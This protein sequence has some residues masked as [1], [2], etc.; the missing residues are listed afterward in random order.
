MTPMRSIFVFF[1]FLLLN[2]AS[3]FAFAVEIQEWAVPFENSRPR[4]PYVDNLGRVWFCG[5]A[6]G[7]LAYLN[8]QT[9]E[10]KKYDLEQGVR[11]H[12][13]IIDKENNVWFAANTKPFIGKLNPDSGIIEKYPM[14]AS[15][16]TDPHTL[17][18]DSLGNIW[19]TAHS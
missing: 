19:F 7:Y 6:G 18:F 11:P 3:S 1:V 14:P 5:Q 12:N 9:G 15:T 4:D 17:V 2:T 8:P 13:L 10:F 16:A